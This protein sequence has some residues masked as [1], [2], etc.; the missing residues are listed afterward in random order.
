MSAVQ[1]AESTNHQATSLLWKMLTEHVQRLASEHERIAASLVR[2]SAEN[3]RLQGDF[4]RLQ[5]VLAHS[6]GRGQCQN[7][8]A[9]SDASPSACPPD[10]YTDWEHEIPSERNP[11]RKIWTEVPPD[12]TSEDVARQKSS[13][14]MLDSPYRQ[15]SFATVVASTSTERRENLMTIKESAQSSTALYDMASQIILP[16]PCENQMMQVSSAPE[17]LGHLVHSGSQ[18]HASQSHAMAHQ[19]SRH[20][21]FHAIDEQSLM[22]AES[23]INRVTKYTSAAE[24]GASST[25][26]G[27]SH[28][29]RMANGSKSSGERISKKRS[30]TKKRQA[31]ER[32]NSKTSYTSFAHAASWFQRI[33]GHKHSEKAA[34]VTHVSTAMSAVKESN[35]N[36]TTPQ[37]SRPLS[38]LPSTT[39]V[40][41]SGAN[42]NLLFSGGEMHSSSVLIA[43]DIVTSQGRCAQRLISA[44]SDRHRVAWDLLGGILVLYD[45]FMIPFVQSFEPEEEVWMRFMTWFGA[46]FWAIDLPK[47]MFSGYHRRGVL[48][49][50]LYK[51]IRKYLRTWFGFDLLVLCIDWVFLYVQYYTTDSESPMR[52]MRSG[53]WLRALRI[54][55]ACRL[56]RLARVLR[57]L[58]TVMNSFSTEVLRVRL[59]AIVALI[60]IV[61]LNHIIA[62]LWYW[63]GHVGSFE[64]NW[65]MAYGLDQRELSYKY[66]T[67]LH[68]ALTQ[69]TPASM[70]VF[71]ANSL[72]RIFTIFTL[73]FGLFT[74]SSFVS[75][76]TQ[77]MTQLFMLTHDRLCQ[78]VNMRRYFVENGLSMEVTDK[79]LDFLEYRLK[80][81]QRKIQE[82]DVPILQVLPERI[83]I[84]MHVEIFKPSLLWIPFFEYFEELDNARLR[85]ICHAAVSEQSLLPDQE[86]FMKGAAAGSVYFVTRGRLSYHRRGEECRVE[87]GSWVS[88]AALWMNWIH[89]GRMSAIAMTELYL[90]DVSV[91][92]VFI[93]CCA[94]NSQTWMFCTCYAAEFAKLDNM[95]G[96]H[97]LS[98]LCHDVEEMSIVADNAFQ[99]ALRHGG[100]H[101]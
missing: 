32:G 84:Q 55:R 65:L 78:N 89:R 68:W 12:F 17:R 39:V 5:R 53:R 98:D 58:N 11:L 96:G 79:I 90:L 48:E 18:S 50:R 38:N 37:P 71:P 23:M 36:P 77:K 70:E 101:P 35:S 62:C 10:V 63:M 94:Q 83:R 82:K 80:D 46:V 3:H 4:S 41:I 6:G 45:V 66:T 25:D 20:P 75:A 16:E 100:L 44:P 52:I 49:M 73:V 42:E 67:S 14:D 30:T 8:L 87:S 93:S 28:S 76:I 72:E 95:A 74:F 22:K 1:W 51:V 91:F 59:Q 29:R 7:V 85:S 40:R 19:D 88:E 9:Q 56:I 21:I 99:Q 15:S 92:N 43:G 60:G 34:V 26:M 57:F 2:S 61:V 64:D 97:H 54:L 13:G 27:S 31:E 24:R 86:L 47:S 33:S 81:S 69:C